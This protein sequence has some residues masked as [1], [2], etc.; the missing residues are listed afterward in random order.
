M[1][2]RGVRQPVVIRAVVA[3]RVAFA[4]FRARLRV[5]LRGF[6]CSLPARRGRWPRRGDRHARGQRDRRVLELGRRECAERVRRLREA[7]DRPHSPR[8]YRPGSFPACTSML[9]SNVAAPCS[10]SQ[11]RHTGRPSLQRSR[12]R[13]PTRSLPRSP[14]NGVS[15]ARRRVRHE[16]VASRPC[17]RVRPDRRTRSQTRLRCRPRATRRA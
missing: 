9:G 15:R 14:V 1:A 5:D 12:S 13:L 6:R 7:S 11:P 4:E 16:R 8:G 3:A 10:R 17:R 2:R